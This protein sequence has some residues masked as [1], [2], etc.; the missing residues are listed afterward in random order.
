M[1]HE[2][3]TLPLLRTSQVQVRDFT[4]AE[5]QAYARENMAVQAAEIAAL[6]GAASAD[7]DPK[8][9][10]R[11]RFQQVNH[12]RMRLLGEA[13]NHADEIAALKA[14]YLRACQTIAAMHE[15]ATGRTGEAPTLGV[16]EDV[17]ALRKDALW[18]RGLRD[19]V[20]FGLPS[21]EGSSQKAAYLVVTGYGDTEDAALTDMAVDATLAK[22]VQPVHACHYESAVGRVCNKCG[23]IHG[24]LAQAVQPEDGTV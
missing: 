3:T 7:F 12:E 22:A 21:S 9:H 15:A 5:M 13:N 18:Y 24:T 4:L 8:V 6:K 2:L 14:D 11:R 20:I 1:Q 10:W 19:A 16:V 23:A 17:A